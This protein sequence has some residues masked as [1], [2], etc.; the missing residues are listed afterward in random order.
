MVAAATVA[1][2]LAPARGVGLFSE[3][4]GILPLEWIL[5]SILFGDLLFNL[6]RTGCFQRSVSKRSG[7]GYERFRIEWFAVDLLA[8]VPFA[9]LPVSPVF[10]LVRLLKLARVAQL[11]QQGAQAAVQHASL[12]RLTFFVFWAALCS[13]WIACGWLAL[14]GISAEITNAENYLKALYWCVTTLTT[15]GYGDIVPST[16]GQMIFSMA[17]MIL[18]V[19]VYGYII[20]KVASIL[21]NIDPAK[22]RYRELVE[23]LSAFM[24]Y[25]NIPVH[26]QERILH[27][28]AY[29]WDKRLGYDE[30]SAIAG[31]P[32][33][34]KADV[35]LFLNRDIIQKVPMFAGA[36]EE[37]VRA[38]A[39]EMQPMIFTPGD[40]VLRTGEPGKEMYFISRGSVEIVSGDGKSVTAKLSA[41]DY[42]GEIA[43]LLDRPR[44]ACVRAVEYCDLYTLEK[45]KFDRILARFPDFAEEI[46]AMAKKRQDSNE[47]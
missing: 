1:G 14:R 45:E 44:M 2:V 12:L 35:L 16:P 9:L 32:P 4:R 11:M 36:S 43:L 8:V 10:G 34:L 25:R 37:F 46:A 13:H 15:V 21:A 18:G 6:H 20:A 17:V 3:G 31:L 30:S 39:L 5:T 40:Y 19:G 7:D 23:R 24:R 42:F 33:S 26:L 38:V 41:G 29:L 28:N 47:L 27:Y 22:V